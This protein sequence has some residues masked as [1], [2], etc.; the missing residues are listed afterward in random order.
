MINPQ[1][2]NNTINNKC[3]EKNYILL[4]EFDCSRGYSTRK[5]K[6]K[7]EKDNYE[8]ETNYYNFL[9][10]NKGCPE[11]AN[12]ITLNKKN[13]KQKILEKCKKYNY[14][15]VGDFIY[16]NNES[17]INIKCNKHDYIWDISYKNFIAVSWWLSFAYK[18]ATSMGR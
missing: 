1:E 10:Q 11:C 2:L 18:L 5:I 12:N 16:K 15:L 13:V 14:S 6:L 3:N 4:E 9:K 8:W 17:R 7:C